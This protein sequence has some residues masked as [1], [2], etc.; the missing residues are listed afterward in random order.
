MTSQDNRTRYYRLLQVGK[1]ELAMDEA[2]YRE[3]LRRHGAQEKAG[4]VSATTMPIGGLAA[5]VMELRQKGFK[6]RN[7]KRDWRT[8]RIELIR[9]LW[10]ALADAGVVRKRDEAAM[11]RWCARITKKARLEWSDS[12]GLS[13]CIEGLKDWAH[14]EGVRLDD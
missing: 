4:K 7:P 6:P 14:R 12:R 3:L 8:P 5:A 13:Q 9:A 2:D 11:Q 1:R 10:H